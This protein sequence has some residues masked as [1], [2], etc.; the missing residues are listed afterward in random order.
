MT[1]IT[2]VEMMNGST[3]RP[4]DENVRPRND[5]IMA[6]LH[7]MDGSSLWS[8]SVW[9]APVGVDLE[10]GIPSA[11]EYMQ[12]AGSAE[13]MS[14][15]VRFVDTDGTA[16][17]Y[18]IGKTGDDAAALTE[19]IRWADG[20]YSINVR[21]NEVF[22][23]DEAAEVYAAYCLTDR[24]AGPYVLRELD[25]SW[26]PPADD[27]EADAA[28]EQIEVEI[29]RRD[30]HP[31]DQGERTTTVEVGAHLP[32]AALLARVIEPFLAR[33]PRTA[34]V[35]SGNSRGQWRD[36]AEVVTFGPPDRLGIGLLVRDHSIG[37]FFGAS[38]GTFRVVCRTATLPLVPAGSGPAQGTLSRPLTFGDESDDEQQWA[39]GDELA[40]HEAFWNFVVDRRSDDN[41]SFTIEDEVRSEMLG[42]LLTADTTVRIEMEPERRD[43]YR[44]V[45]D[46][47]EY[48]AQVSTF[49]SGGFAALDRHGPWL[50]DMAAVLGA[51]L[52]LEMDE[53]TLRRTHPRELRRRLAVLTRIDG[54]EPVTTAGITHYGYAADDGS[55]VDAWFAVDGRGLLVTNDRTS[56]LAASDARAQAA[57]REGVPADLLALAGDAPATGIFTFAGPC[58]MADGVVSRLQE[59][60]RGIA[61]TGVERLLEPFLEI[62]SFSPDA[63]SGVTEWW[64]DAAIA[65]GFAAAADHERA[66]AVDEALTAA[67]FD[68]WA[69]EVLRLAWATTGYHDAWDVHYVLFDSCSLEEA[70]ETR[71]ELLRAI[72]KLGLDLVDT[73]PGAADGEVWVRT[74]P[75]TDLALE[76]PVAQQHPVAPETSGLIE[77][78]VRA[79]TFPWSEADLRAVASPPYP[80]PADLRPLIDRLMA[81]LPEAGPVAAP[82]GPYVPSSTRHGRRTMAHTG[83]PRV[84]LDLVTRGILTRDDGERLIEA[85]AR[86]DRAPTD[87]D[88]V[89]RALRLRLV[90]A[91]LLADDVVAAERVA[92]QIPDPWPHLGWREIARYHAARGGATAFLRGWSHYDAGRDRAEMQRLKR[93]LVSA[94]AMREGWEAALE[95]C[96][97]ARIGDAFRLHAFAPPAYGYDDLVTLFG[98]EAAGALAEVDELHCLVAAAVAESRPRPLA[99]HRGVEALLA[100][101]AALDADESREAMRA[102]DHLLSTLRMA[103][104]SED[105]LARLRAQIRTPRLRSEAMQVFTGPAESIAGEGA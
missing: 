72:A 63:V 4:I 30:A 90:E 95:T 15:E 3:R 46:F 36:F 60:Q 22:T 89:V 94:I 28:D 24:V 49:V 50:D 83:L 2:H 88:L 44:V 42:L 61:D 65:S 102:R 1:R 41:T 6:M 56:P 48:T 59:E 105:T 67:S 73:P 7:R 92:A 13:A 86:M 71:D 97:D 37:S 74:D 62:E 81:A 35:C 26:T 79:L 17:Q 64:S 21:R 58:A 100:R 70:G 54:S 27:D 103:V 29:W 5:Q 19:E 34:W 53:S 31:G 8:Y 85:A 20:R 45:S 96:R 23:A 87:R 68:P 32:L 11:D 38:E 10:Q 16:H 33:A 98:G 69:I 75:R 99:D 25:L 91:S 18:A 14:V 93:S 9:R 82:I 66:Q 12:S 57:L 76:A 52:R 55:S 80:L 104:G 84:L 78:A 77:I 51:R 39:P 43:G 47:G 101:V 40:A